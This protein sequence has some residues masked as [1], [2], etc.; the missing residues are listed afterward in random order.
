MGDILSESLEMFKLTLPNMLLGL[1]LANLIRHSPHFKRVIGEPMSRLASISNLPSECSAVL[2]MFFVN[3]WATLAMLSDF[4]RKKLVREREVIVTMLVGFFPKGVHV[5]FLMT[6]IAISVLGVIG[7][8]YMFMELLIHIA[9]TI[10]GIIIGRILLNPAPVA[11]KSEE[12]VQEVQISWADRL[13]RSFKDSMALFKR[14]IIVFV[15]SVI[16]IQ[17]LINLGL[18]NI[19]TEIC[20]TF[21]DVIGLPTSS[22][23]VIAASFASQMAAIAAA[24]TLLKSGLL[25]PTH[26]LLLLFIAHFLHMG[27]GCIRLGLPMNISLFGRSLGLKATLITYSMLELN[28]AFIILLLYSII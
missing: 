7:G 3:N 28:M 11:E 12:N 23:I 19:V 27:I 24:G 13:K 25:P 22:M 15:P 16:V 14:T 4:Y 20:G 17:L 21:F 26:C 18:L 9:I 1:F 5:V 8:L 10:I 6:P 2:M